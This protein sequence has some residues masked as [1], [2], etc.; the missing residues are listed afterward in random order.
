MLVL[1]GN[2]DGEEKK[3]KWEPLSPDNMKDEN[4]LI[5]IKLEKPEYKYLLKYV[6]RQPVST[7]EDEDQPSIIYAYYRC[8]NSDNRENRGG[9]IAVVDPI[10]V[11]GIRN[12]SRRRPAQYL[13][14]YGFILPK[15]EHKKQ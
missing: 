3:F 9:S 10:S 15:C 7:V 11:Q 5:A 13:T 6:A 12:G 8:V 1:T 2:A 4:L 14:T